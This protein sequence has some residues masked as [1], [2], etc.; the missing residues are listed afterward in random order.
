MLYLPK[1]KWYTQGPQTVSLIA[2]PH[3]TEL[4]RDQVPSRNAGNEWLFGAAAALLGGF[5]VAMPDLPGM[6]GADPS[7]YHPFCHADS[8]AYSVVD[9][10]RTVREVLEIDLRDTYTWDGRLYIMGYSEGGYAA[11]ATVRELQLH[12]TDYPGLA[13]TGSACMAGPQD[14]SGAMRQLMIDPNQHFGRPFFLPY[15]ILGYNAVYAGGPFAPSEAMQP[16]LLPDIVAWMNETQGG[17][18]VDTL[19]EQ[20]LGVATGQVVPLGMMN[21]QWVAAQLADDVYQTSTVGQILAANNL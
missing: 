21:P 3:G 16:T 11:L 14:L 5:A 12:A 1:R 15:L 9:M 6:G 7:Q 13:I 17:N 18:P 19:I 10:V 4:D 20:R 8:L 2:Y